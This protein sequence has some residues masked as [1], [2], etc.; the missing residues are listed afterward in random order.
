MKTH[1]PHF[2]IRMLETQNRENEA[3]H[4]MTLKTEQKPK[5]KVKMAG[6]I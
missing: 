1:G 4:P 6:L 5:R 3:G 2:I